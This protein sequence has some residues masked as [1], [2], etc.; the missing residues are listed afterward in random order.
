MMW[1][2]TKHYSSTR[3]RK[4]VIAPNCVT[5]NNVPQQPIY[6]LNKG[7][8]KKLTRGRGLCLCSRTFSS[9]PL[10]SNLDKWDTQRPILTVPHSQVS[11]IARTCAKQKMFH[12]RTKEKCPRQVSHIAKS[13][14]AT[15]ECY[16]QSYYCSV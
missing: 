14:I 1:L 5:S 16:S 7:L 6:R 15:F 4:P 13:H 9:I 8:Y 2:Y 10:Q 12:R 11:H 3:C